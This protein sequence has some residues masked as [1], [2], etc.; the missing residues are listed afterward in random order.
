MM[1][2]NATD[3][4]VFVRRQEVWEGRLDSRVS[5][6]DAFLSFLSMSRRCL[7]NRSPSLFC[8]S[9]MHKCLLKVHFMH[10]ITL[11]KVHVKRTVILID[12][13]G[14]QVWRSCVARPLT[15]KQKNEIIPFTS[16]TFSFKTSTK[17][18]DPVV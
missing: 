4:H 12:R 18:R 1:N 13:F 7:R 15:Q 16:L 3:C 5:G 9:S 10:Q 14:P 8:D 11:G 17:F 2:R 6:L